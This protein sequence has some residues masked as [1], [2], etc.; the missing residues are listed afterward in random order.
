METITVTSDHAQ[1][2]WRE[3]IAAAFSDKNEVVIE[4]QG[5][6]VATLVNYELFQKIK[7][8]LL[9]LQGLKNAEKNRQERLEKP[10]ST[11]TLS[12]LAAKLNL[13]DPQETISTRTRP[14]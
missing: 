13:A 3:T 6:P 9:I 2:N 1:L 11:V 4:Q 12:D 5:K 10:L 14:I 8:E 7:R